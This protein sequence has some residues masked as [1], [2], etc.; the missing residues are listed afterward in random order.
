[1]EALVV[2][3]RKRK[4]L[5]QKKKKTKKTKRRKEENNWTAH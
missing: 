1:M 5:K 4:W 2:G 3:P